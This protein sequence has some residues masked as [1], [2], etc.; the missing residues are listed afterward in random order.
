MAVVHEL[1]SDPAIFQMSVQNVK[2]YE[3][4]LNDRN[5]QIGDILHIRETSESGEAMSAGAELRYTGRIMVRK[6]N[7][8]LSGYGLKEGWVILNVRKL[9]GR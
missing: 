2:D 6:I 1:K 9:R 8:I 4:R 5:F 7:S 3:L